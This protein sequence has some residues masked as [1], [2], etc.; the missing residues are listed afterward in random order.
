NVGRSDPR[1]AAALREAARTIGA[2]EPAQA[3]LAA[4]D[5]ALRQALEAA[6][7]QTSLR[8]TT[9]KLQ[10]LE[11]QAATGWAV[12]AD[13]PSTSGTGDSSFLPQGYTSESGTP[14][15]LD[16]GG[17]QLRDP[18][19]A[20]GPG[21][22][23]GAGSD[24]AAQTQAVAGTAAE[25]VF[26]PGREGSGPGDQSLTDQTFSVRGAPRPYRDVLSQYAQSGRDYVDRPDVSPAVRDLVKQ[27]FQKLEEGQ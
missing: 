9:Q 26:V 10:D 20:A 18:S 17:G 24:L 15:A 1:S 6:N 7:A 14:I 12:N 22:G 19:A 23:F 2:G 27:Y 25:S 4:T 3:A 16:A 5:E 11:N 13:A 8:Q 21:A